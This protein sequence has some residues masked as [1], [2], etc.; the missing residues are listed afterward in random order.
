MVFTPRTEGG[1]G[2]WSYCTQ[3]GAYSSASYPR[4]RHNKIHPYVLRVVGF[5]HQRNRTHYNVLN[6]ST[7]LATSY[8]ARI[9]TLHRCLCRSIS[10]PDS[11]EIVTPWQSMSHTIFFL[12]SINVFLHTHPLTTY[13]QSISFAFSVVDE[14]LPLLSHR[15]RQQP[16][17][18][19]PSQ[20]TVS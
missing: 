7:Q 17:F 20:A 5:R 19:Q 6:Q 3:C 18:R 8:N 14:L 13:R 1:R 15:S 12:P 11:P 9:C 2:D 4:D 10:M 16:Y